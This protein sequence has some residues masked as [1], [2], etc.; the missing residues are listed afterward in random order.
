MDVPLLLFDQ[1]AIL[2]GTT[3]SE[4]TARRPRGAVNVMND[5]LLLLFDQEAILDGTTNSEQTARRQ[6]GVRGC[7]ILT[8]NP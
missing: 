2:D 1:E 5:V 3:N 4:Q 7:N 8:V 6:R